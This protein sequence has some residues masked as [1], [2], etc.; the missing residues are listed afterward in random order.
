MTAPNAAAAA[1]Q[2]PPEPAA[3]ESG[4][5]KDHTM[6]NGLL[7]KALLGLLGLSAT[8][9]GGGSLSPGVSSAA[10]SCKT[11]SACGSKASVIS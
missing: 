2:A 10:G 4:Q 7:G 6:H 1:P 3:G 9:G 5:Q 11:A 8:Y